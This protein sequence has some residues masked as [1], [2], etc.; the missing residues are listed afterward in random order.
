MGREDSGELLHRGEVSTERLI[1]EPPDLGFAE[2]LGQV[3]KCA[4]D[5]RDWNPKPGCSLVHGE[6]VAVSLDPREPS[7]F[8]MS[9][10]EKFVFAL[11]DQTPER[12]RA[13]M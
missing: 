9:Y 10:F 6:T 11:V 1:N 4:F 3:E 12:G 7:S 13:P 2:G 5:G 8:G